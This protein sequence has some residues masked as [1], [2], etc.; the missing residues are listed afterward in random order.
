MTQEAITKQHYYSELSE[1]GEEIGQERAI[2]GIYGRSNIK[3]QL[4]EEWLRL[5]Y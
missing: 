3:I 1:L 2:A 5:L 4:A